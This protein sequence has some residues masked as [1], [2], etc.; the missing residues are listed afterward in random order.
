MRLAFCGVLLWREGHVLL[1]DPSPHCTGEVRARRPYVA[2]YPR[3]LG[4]R[5]PTAPVR[6]RGRVSS[7][8]S[9]A[10][11]VAVW[12][13]DCS[14]VAAARACCRRPAGAQGLS[15]RDVVRCASRGPNQ[16]SRSAAG[17]DELR[18]WRPVE[19]RVAPA[20]AVS[21]A[22]I[23]SSET[24]A[25]AFAA[26][27]RRAARR[28]QAGVIG[29]SVP[30]RGP[31]AP[32]SSA[33]RGHAAVRRHPV[34]QRG[35]SSPPAESRRTSQASAATYLRPNRLCLSEVRW[36]HEGNVSGS[37]NVCSDRFRLSLRA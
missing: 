31:R 22:R 16:A 21:R 36:F 10:D 24:A 32:G 19:A 2:F 14:V 35:R 29:S 6:C 18:D 13:G 20:A 15:F 26:A 17:T 1:L 28:V 7:A 4:R 3:L 25:A 30:R 9:D 33:A 23:A 34:W 12:L 11:A 5:R 37:G 27:I 8:T